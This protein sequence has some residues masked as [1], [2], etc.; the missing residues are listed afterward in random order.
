[1]LIIHKKFGIRLFFNLVRLFFKLIDKTEEYSGTFQAEDEP[2][3]ME[4]L[5]DAGT[6]DLSPHNPSMYGAD[7]ILT[8]ELLTFNQTIEETNNMAPVAYSVSAADRFEKRECDGTVIG[9]SC[10][11][12]HTNWK[13]WRDAQLDCYSRQGYLVEIDDM[14]EWNALHDIKR[15]LYMSL[16]RLGS[17]YYHMWVGAGQSTNTWYW[18]GTGAEVDLGLTISNSG[19]NGCLCAYLTKFYS[20]PCSDK[21]G[22]ICDYS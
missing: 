5:F 17:G 6:P 16:V 8:P 15:R 22:Y 18:E 19:Y 10:Y 2:H 11:T 14:T 3:P 20:V 9:G 1:M 21:R 7:L 12:V 13:S 4:D